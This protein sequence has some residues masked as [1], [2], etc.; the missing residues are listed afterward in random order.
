MFDLS[1]K[2]LLVKEKELHDTAILLLWLEGLI[3]EEAAVEK[4]GSY[5]AY[6]KRQ[7]IVSSA[8]QMYRDLYGEGV[9]MDSEGAV[10]PMK[11]PISLNDYLNRITASYEAH[12]AGPVGAEK[13]ALLT[14]TKKQFIEYF[15][16]KH[17]IAFPENKVEV[18]LGENNYSK[19]L[20]MAVSWL[21]PAGEVRIAMQSSISMVCDDG[22]Y[23]W[24]LPRTY[25][26]GNEWRHWNNP[27]VS[28]NGEEAR[29]SNVPFIKALIGACV[30]YGTE[31]DLARINSAERERLG[32]AV[33]AGKEMYKGFEP[34]ECLVFDK[35]SAAKIFGGKPPV[36]LLGL[37]V[38]VVDTLT[39]IWLLSAFVKN[40]TITRNPIPSYK[41][42]GNVYIDIVDLVSAIPKPKGSI[43][44]VSAGDK[45]HYTD[46]IQLHDGQRW[47]I[48]STEG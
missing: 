38:K 37:E 12:H 26:S 23:R 10:R 4:L 28:I 17:K 7:E 5:D 27:T 16:A 47:L 24:E 42:E 39:G 6:S 19:F 14:K 2:K 21:S 34:A 29:K 13:E 31:S 11:Q 46:G 30:S 48:G 3:S 35:E 1:D 33:K 9:E 45:R 22:I 40:P 20:E 25:W 18:S 15:L 36:Y 32:E 44:L 41:T 8:V 43:S